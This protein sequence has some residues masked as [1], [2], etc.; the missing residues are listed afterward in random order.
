MYPISSNSLS[1]RET[2]NGWESSYDSERKG[3][4]LVEDDDRSQ[5]VVER[6]EEKETEVEEEEKH[7]HDNGKPHIREPNEEEPKRVWLDTLANMLKENH[8]VNR[9][10][11]ILKAAFELILAE[12]SLEQ[13]TAGLPEYDIALTAIVAAALA[14]CFTG[15]DIVL[16][17]RFKRKI[18]FVRTQRTTEPLWETVRTQ[19]EKAR[20]KAWPERYEE[21]IAAKRAD[22]AFGSFQSISNQFNIDLLIILRCCGFRRRRERRYCRLACW[23]DIDEGDDALTLETDGW[24]KQT[25]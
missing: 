11:V 9:L 13:T 21:E 17:Y 1:Q 2:Y 10:F 14:L 24:S 7:D 18:D 22:A 19:A 16:F 4:D 5:V 3:E 23:R 25:C 6:E 20:A 8:N 12:T 15:V